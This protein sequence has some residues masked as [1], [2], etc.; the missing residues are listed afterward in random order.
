MAS[1]IPIKDRLLQLDAVTNALLSNDIQVTSPAVDA[2]VT[3]ANEITDVRQITIQ[4]KD[5]NGANITY[6]E[7]VDIILYTTAA[8]AAYVVTGG[9][10]GIAIGASGA[11][12][13]IIAKK[14]FRATTTTAGLLALTYT[15][16]GTEAVALGV[17]LPTGRYVMGSQ[18][19][20]NA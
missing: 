5:A 2:T 9:S 15:D 3:V 13:T 1:L 12:S 10:T 11:L 7:E 17:K 14:V 20:T 16:T 6:A 4:L 8:R 18:L 19:L